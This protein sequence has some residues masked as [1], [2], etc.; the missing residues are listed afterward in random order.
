MNFPDHILKVDRDHLTQNW[1]VRLTA[2]MQIIVAVEEEAS[3]V[4]ARL[5]D[6]VAALARSKNV[7]LAADRIIADDF[8]AA[9]PIA[10]FAAK[11]KEHFSFIA[12]IVET[13]AAN[14]TSLFILIIDL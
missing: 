5:Q 9:A 2:T 12:D 8:I 11:Y 1:V 14:E 3:A 4:A 6:T 7:H 10:H 13:V